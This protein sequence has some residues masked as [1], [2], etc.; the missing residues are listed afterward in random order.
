MKDSATQGFSSGPGSGF[1]AWLLFA[2]SFG[3]WTACDKSELVSTCPDPRSRDGYTLVWSDEFDG[4]VIDSSIWSFDLGDGCDRGADLCGWGNNELQYYTD[5][6]ENARVENGMLS[7]TARR[8]F[9]AYLGRHSYTSARLVTKGKRDFTYGRVDVRA[10]IPE[11]QGIWPAIWLLHSDTTYGIWPASGEIDIMESV[12]NR[13]EEVFGTIHYGHDFWRFSSVDTILPDGTFAEDFH[14]Y[15]VLWT[16]NCIQFLV[17]DAPY[18]APFTRSSVLPTTWPFDH[19]FH[20]ILN[21]AIGG[22][23]PGNPGPSTRFPQT[24]DIDYVRVFQPAD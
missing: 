5:R 17:D 11:T 24:L 16:E 19:D 20:V 14:V 21:V 15:S 4:E 1:F 6:P 18:G 7:I 9:P 10:R 2:S 3:V 23:L 8:E 13:P 12:G 22:N